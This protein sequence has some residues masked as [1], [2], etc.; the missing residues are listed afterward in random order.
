MR[1]TIKLQNTLL[2]HKSFTKLAS[3]CALGMETGERN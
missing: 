1:H 2:I 3:W